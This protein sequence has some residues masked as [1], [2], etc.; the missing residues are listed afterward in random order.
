VLV[1]HDVNI[2]ALVDLPVVPGE[3]VLLRAAAGKLEVLGR[4]WRPD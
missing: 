1:T 2:R 3:A 4:V